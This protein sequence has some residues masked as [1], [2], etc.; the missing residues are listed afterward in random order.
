LGGYEISSEWQAWSKNENRGCHT[1][2]FCTV[3]SSSW[4][5]SPPAK[6]G[7]SSISW[8]GGRQEPAFALTDQFSHEQPDETLK[9]L[10][11]TVLFFPFRRLLTLCKAQLVQLQ[12]AKQRFEAQG[13][14]LAA[15]NQVSGL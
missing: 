7:D 3:W 4:E 13:L 15:I 11:G 6:L 9:G 14:K 8:L 12:D 10:K 2:L 5:E 1:F